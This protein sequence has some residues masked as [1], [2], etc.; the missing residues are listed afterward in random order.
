MVDAGFGAKEIAERLTR[1][2]IEPG[3]ISAVLISHEH[4]DHIEGAAA[5]SKK[6][7]VPVFISPRA[8]DHSPSELR[9]VINFPLS[10]DVPVQIGSIT[11]TPFSAPHD[12]IDPFAFS[13][14]AGSSRVCVVTDIGY[15]SENVRERIIKSDV[16]V[17]ESNHDLEM[18][19]TGPYPWSLKQ[20]VMSNFGHLSNEALAYFFSEYFDGSGRKIVLIHL[21]RQNNHPQIAYVSALR[22]LEKKCKDAELFISSQDEVSEVLDL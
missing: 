3:S 6:F 19:K 18:L 12:S 5:F 16:L 8:L 1:I 13:L 17:I 4:H 7:D 22:S 10:A 2:D 11:V 9:E 14:R 21:S 15:I 20:R